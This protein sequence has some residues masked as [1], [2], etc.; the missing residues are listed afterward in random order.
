M[1]PFLDRVPEEE[2]V[3]ENDIS[4]DSMSSMSSESEVSVY[5][6]MTEDRECLHHFWLEDTESENK[7]LKS[8][9]RPH[10]IKLML[11]KDSL[12]CDE[13]HVPRKNSQRKISIVTGKNNEV[14]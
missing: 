2:K 10:F 9:K 8:V 1:D 12:V 4:I 7:S 6:D 11:K 14:P 13:T 5:T 3:I